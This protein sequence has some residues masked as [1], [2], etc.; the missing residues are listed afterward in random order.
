MPPTP[1]T[2]GISNPERLLSAVLSGTR[3]DQMSP[4]AGG[5]R[6]AIVTG[7]RD[8]LAG[9]VAAAPSVVAFADAIGV[10]RSTLSQLIAPG[11]TRL[12]RAETLVAIAAHCDVSVDWLLGRSSEIGAQTA[13][14]SE[15]LSF[16]H[17]A[18]SPDDERL[19]GWLQEAQGSKIRYVPSTLPDILKSSEVIRH[20]M[21][22]WA[23]ARPEQRIETAAAR[24]A[25]QRQPEAELECCATRQSVESFARGEGIWREL[26][27]DV[28]RTQLATMAELADELYP[29]FRWFLFDGRAQYAAPIT[30]F[31][32]KR[33]VIYIGQ[34]YLVFH[35]VNHV[36]ALA[37]HFDQLIRAAVMQPPDVPAFLLQLRDELG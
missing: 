4:L 30:V 25:W 31:G 1:P 37:A 5:S 29:A 15:Q 14:V 9:L 28:R 12:P 23:T 34:A 11:N 2:T 36:R 13:V 35:T 26:P 24:L 21:A 19:I 8:R 27:I 7:F 3:G 32:L 6:R 33:A 16:E 22:S 18:L 10:D 20:E 17:N